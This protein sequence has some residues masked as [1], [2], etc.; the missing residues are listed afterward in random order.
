MISPYYRIIGT[1]FLRDIWKSGLFKN[2]FN[3]GKQEL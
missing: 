1:A 2:K 3:T